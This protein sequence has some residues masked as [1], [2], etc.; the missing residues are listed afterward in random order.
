MSI[1]YGIEGFIYCIRENFRVDCKIWE[2]LV[3]WER[4]CGKMICFV[5]V[6]C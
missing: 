5:V 6:C 4:F 3:D 2:R 1:E